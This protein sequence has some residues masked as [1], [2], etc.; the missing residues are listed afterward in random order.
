LPWQ[1]IV[2]VLHGG[3]VAGATVV[4]VVA[5]VGRRVVWVVKWVERRMMA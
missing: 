3:L 5:I 1:L 4:V 2:A